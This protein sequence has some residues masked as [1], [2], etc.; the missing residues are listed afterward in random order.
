MFTWTDVIGE[1]DISG[2]TWY[3]S[4]DMGNPKEIHRSDVNEE[5]LINGFMEPGARIIYYK[6]ESQPH[7][8]GFSNAIIVACTGLPIVRVSTDSIMLDPDLVDELYSPGHITI[9]YPEGDTYEI[10]DVADYIK[11]NVERI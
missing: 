7:A 2:V 6:Y 10:D 4:A 5:I 3:E 11:N 9:D 8:S 1:N